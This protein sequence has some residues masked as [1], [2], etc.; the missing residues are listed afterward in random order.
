MRDIEVAYRLLEITN[1]HGIFDARILAQRIREL[2]WRITFV[3]EGYWIHTPEKRT[4]ILEVYTEAETVELLEGNLHMVGDFPARVFLG[5]GL[6]SDLCR[7]MG[8]KPEWDG[9]TI[10][11]G[12]M[13][14]ACLRA[15]R[16]AME[17]KE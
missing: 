14:E 12:K 1:S 5:W 17:N 16:R 13:Y 6:A 4:G 8:L 2:G 10:T 7:L 15:I 9:A 3:G 11:R